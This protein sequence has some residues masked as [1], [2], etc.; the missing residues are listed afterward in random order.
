MTAT[1]E[2]LT[3]EVIFERVAGVST[4]TVQ[5]GNELI[6]SGDTSTAIARPNRQQF[7]IET[8]VQYVGTMR[9]RRQVVEIDTPE[10]PVVDL[11][12]YFYFRPDATSQFFRPDGTSRYVRAK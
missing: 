4:P 9:W 12:D 1:M 8:S 3:A 2:I 10:L 7:E 11:T 5:S 6:F